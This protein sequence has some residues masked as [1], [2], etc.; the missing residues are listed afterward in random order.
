MILGITGCYSDIC[1]SPSEGEST[2][3]VMD[4]SSV[5]DSM[6]N[7]QWPVSYS[8]SACLPPAYPPP[9]P[10]SDMLQSYDDDLS[11]LVAPI[12]SL[13]HAYRESSSKASRNQLYSSTAVAGAA[14]SAYKLV[15]RGSSVSHLFSMAP[16]RKLDLFRVD[17]RFLL[18]QNCLAYMALKAKGN[19][20]FPELEAWVNEFI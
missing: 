2:L 4:I 6:W 19:A 18:Q 10:A 13:F 20:G 3:S 12:S 14:L 7:T 11:P 5:I 1:T 15:R 17:Q 16:V 9:V 8:H